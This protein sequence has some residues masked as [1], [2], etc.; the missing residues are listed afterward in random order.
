ME[1]FAEF[2]ANSGLLDPVGLMARIA[3]IL[4]QLGIVDAFKWLAVGTLLFLVGY[5]LLV[6]TAQLRAQAFLSILLRS[7]LVGALLAA[8]PYLQM[9]TLNLYNTAWS[10]GLKIGG[11]ILDYN[12]SLTQNYGFLTSAAT[13]LGGAGALAILGS[14]AVRAGSRALD[15]LARKEGN[16]AALGNTVGESTAKGLSKALDYLNIFAL[17]L[18]P[19]MLVFAVIAVTSGITVLIATI[20]LPVLLTFVILNGPAATVN[21]LNPFY[22]AVAGSYLLALLVP[23]IFGIAAFAAVGVPMQGF[24]QE[25]DAALQKLR[26]TRFWELGTLLSLVGTLIWIVI[27]TGVQVVVGIILGY[28][29]INKASETVLHFVGGI[30]GLVRSYAEAYWSGRLGGSTLRGL[31]RTQAIQTAATATVGAARLGRWTAATGMAT[32]RTLYS[33]AQAKGLVP[34][35]EPPDP[36]AQDLATRRPLHVREWDRDSAYDRALRWWDRKRGQELDHRRVFVDNKD[37][38]GG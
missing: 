12:A 2:L 26:E 24:S 21:F 5:R 11:Q 17:I 9:A 10:V 38:Q 25:L 36:N 22:R 28:F 27:R 4:A 19:L 31:A 15:D 14:S 16:A 18:L 20:L 30:G 7:L 33:D 32:G 3:A 37:E 1:S 13:F 29:I 6:A 35:V 34:G 23:I 8:T